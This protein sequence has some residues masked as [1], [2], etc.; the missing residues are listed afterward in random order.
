MAKEISEQGWFDS[1][2][3]RRPRISEE[4]TRRLATAISEGVYRAG[5]FLPSE[6]ELMQRFG[7]GRPAVREALFSLRKMGL[8]AIHSGT[9]SQVTKP[10]GLAVISE[11][12][13]IVQHLL[14]REDGVRQFQQVRTLF[15]TALA[16][17][18]ALFGSAED[19]AQIKLALDRNR[20]ALGD[21]SRFIRADIGFHFAIASRT[22][23]PLIV[24]IHD[25]MAAW[26]RDQRVVT[27]TIPGLDK[28]ALA[29]HEGIYEA[30]AAHDGDRAE[31]L[32]RSHIEHVARNYWTVRDRHD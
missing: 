12:S 28:I 32:M 7:V 11:L 29:E 2:P 18:A 23:N 13:G 25:A 10:D 26:L 8:I 1:E 21:K 30:I 31:S 5:D 20:D 6:R 16:R 19:L 3:I 14:N 4:V 27:L 22:K 15:E 24:Q 17:E 9:R